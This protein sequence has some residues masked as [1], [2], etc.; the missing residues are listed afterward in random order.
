M[1]QQSSFL[2]DFLALLVSHSP[3]VSFPRRAR[4]ETFS[5]F[6]FPEEQK[7]GISFPR[8]YL[9]LFLSLGQPSAESGEN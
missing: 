8:G 1:S 4:K 2:Y 9:G 5:E 6:P 7:P 3:G